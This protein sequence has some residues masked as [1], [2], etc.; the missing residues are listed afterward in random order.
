MLVVVIFYFQIAQF[1]YTHKRSPTWVQYVVS[2]HSY[3][4]HVGDTP[5]TPQQDQ[6]TRFIQITNHRKKE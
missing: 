6:I 3:E 2:H 1:T 4:L 5:P